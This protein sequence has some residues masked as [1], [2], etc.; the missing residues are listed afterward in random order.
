MVAIIGYGFRVR[1]E[2]KTWAV[3]TVLCLLIADG[4]AF[5]C[6]ALVPK[7]IGLL[8]FAC[9]LGIWFVLVPVLYYFSGYGSKS[10][11]GRTWLGSIWWWLEYLL[12]TTAFNLTV[13]AGQFL[14]WSISYGLQLSCAAAASWL[15]LLF[16][17]F[18]KNRALKRNKISV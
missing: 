5:I 6:S 2:N 4:I 14:G 13:T 12:M 9:T 1:R 8:C 11:P 18:L 10:F 16:V 15:L 17:V 3:W 7:D